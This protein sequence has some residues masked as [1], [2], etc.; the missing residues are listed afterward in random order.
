MVYWWMWCSKHIEIA[1]LVSENQTCLAGKSISCRWDL[2]LKPPYFSEGISNGQGFGRIGWSRK[3]IRE[4]KQSEESRWYNIIYI[5]IYIYTI[6]YIYIYSVVSIIYSHHICICTFSQ[7]AHWLNEKMTNLKPKVQLCGLSVHDAYVF[8]CP[9]QT[10]WLYEVTGSILSDT[11]VLFNPFVI[12]GKAS[13]YIYQ[14]KKK[15]FDI[16]QLIYSSAGIPT[17]MAPAFL[18]RIF[19]NQS[20]DGSSPP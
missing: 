19:R 6:Y 14:L 2:W 1:Q 9:D 3:K 11:L 17:C 10:G 12:N 8:W 16:Y 5:Y 4:E 15:C 18:R 20:E 13:N 7:Y